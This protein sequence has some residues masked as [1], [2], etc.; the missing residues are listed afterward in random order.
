MNKSQVQYISD[1]QG[2]VTGVILPIQ[3]WRDIVSELE[4]QHLMKSDAM[5]QRL[6]EAKRRN[7]GIPFDTA[8]NQLG[9][10]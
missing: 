5:W 9:L 10:E 4:T 3:L 6:I 2:E 7:E 1:D 8:V